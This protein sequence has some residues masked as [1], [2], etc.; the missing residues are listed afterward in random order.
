MLPDEIGYCV[1]RLLQILFS[2]VLYIKCQK[3]TKTARSNILELE[4]MP[5]NVLSDQQAK[6]PKIFSLLSCMTPKS[7][8]TSHLRI[9]KKQRQLNDY[10][11]IRIVANYLIKSQTSQKRNTKLLTALKDVCQSGPAVLHGLDQWFPT[12]VACNPLK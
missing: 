9:C 12:F 10:L 2:V 4:V 8:K 3:T 5:S 6:T 7:I 11:I 1:Y